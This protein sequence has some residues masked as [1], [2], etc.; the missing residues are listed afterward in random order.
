MKARRCMRQLV[1]DNAVYDGHVS[2]SET[3]TRADVCD[4]HN[5]TLLSER[6]ALLSI[7]TIH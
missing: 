1:A 2:P 6:A 4:A 3:K 7:R 5:N